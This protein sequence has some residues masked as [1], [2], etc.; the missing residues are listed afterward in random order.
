MSL[1]RRRST[2][3]LDF[4]GVNR[5]LSFHSSPTPCSPNPAGGRRKIFVF[6]EQSYCG[7][8]PSSPFSP[9]CG[10]TQPLDV[11]ASETFAAPSSSSATGI[12]HSTQSAK[13]SAA[14]NTPAPQP[15]H[16]H[17]QQQHHQ[18]QQHQQHQKHHRCAP[19]KPLSWFQQL[20]LRFY[21]SLFLRAVPAWCSKTIDEFSAL[22]ICMQ[23]QQPTSVTSPN[24]C[25]PSTPSTSLPLDTPTP[26][27]AS[28]EGTPILEGFFIAAVHLGLC[29]TKLASL[30]L[31]AP[32]L[33]EAFHL[34]CEEL[35]SLLW[36]SLRE[37]AS[38]SACTAQ[39]TDPTS[40]VAAALHLQH[41]LA[42]SIQAC[43]ALPADAR[44]GLVEA[45]EYA[46]VHLTDAS[47]VRCWLSHAANAPHLKS[48]H[49][50]LTQYLQDA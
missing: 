13:E 11:E 23:Q 27:C 29:D 31:A 26:A 1:A 2:R 6:G 50:S 12:A 24:P 22:L 16:H 9:E 32:S 40:F 30:T 5:R 45:L 4:K 19:K 37:A 14:L 41:E 10:Q 44:A 49:T 25:A 21:K 33:F 34:V 3:T 48:L 7:S 15:K 47:C 20:R 35:H 38:S 42:S 18:H 17:Q 36:C 43:T 8:T 28:S 39:R 46:F